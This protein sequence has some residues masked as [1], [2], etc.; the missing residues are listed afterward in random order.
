MITNYFNIYFSFTVL[1]FALTILCD[2]VIKSESERIAAPILKS[3]TASCGA[4]NNQASG[5][6]IGFCTYSVGFYSNPNG[7]GS[8]SYDAS[9]SIVKNNI[10]SNYE[11]SVQLN[12]PYFI[13]FAVESGD[14][15]EIQFI[16]SI[17]ATPYIPY[18]EVYT[19]INGQGTIIQSSKDTTRIPI[20]NTCTSNTA[21]TFTLDGLTTSSSWPSASASAIVCVNRN[22]VATFIGTVLVFPVNKGD[23]IS[24][25][26]PVT[27]PANQLQL[28]VIN[29]DLSL[30]IFKW[31][32]NAYYT[33]L[34]VRN[35]CV[36]QLP[37]SSPFGTKL[38][39]IYPEEKL[40]EFLFK[41]S[42]P[43]STRWYGLGSEEEIGNE[44]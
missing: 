27:S 23:T 30:I 11:I 7:G 14:N 35:F 44:E 9:V 4:T 8:T 39:P 21:C 6:N 33:P 16:V 15:V 36:L 42:A 40:K 26:L 5:N 1:L 10:A 17:A 3:F 28:V 38:Y 20:T 32:S 29:D 12:S 24:I 41:I 18:F 43:I 19:S 34:Q 37:S 13:N 25:I 31:F 2:E 22:Q